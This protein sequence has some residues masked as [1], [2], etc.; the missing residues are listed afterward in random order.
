MNFFLK[1]KKMIPW[2]MFVSLSYFTILI[3]RHNSWFEVLTIIFG[4]YPLM[5]LVNFFIMVGLAT[6]FDC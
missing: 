3:D 5:C 1:H 4:L 2:A 6:R